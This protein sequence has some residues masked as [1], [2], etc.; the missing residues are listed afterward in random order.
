MSAHPVFC[1]TLVIEFLQPYPLTYG[2]VL[3]GQLISVCSAVCQQI[4]QP[5]QFFLQH[6]VFLLQGHD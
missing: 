5:G 6:S 2:T 1:E 4:L 3:D